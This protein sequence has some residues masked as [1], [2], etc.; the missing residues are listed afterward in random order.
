[1]I[2]ATFWVTTNIVFFPSGN[3][4]DLAVSSNGE[5]CCTVSDDKTAKVFDVVNFGEIIFSCF[6]FF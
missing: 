1:M 3:I 5:F 6:R 4:Q 2:I